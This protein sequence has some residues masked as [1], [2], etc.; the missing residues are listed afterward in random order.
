HWS[1]ASGTVSLSS[2][3]SHASPWAS[4]S[5][6][7]WL[8]F[9]VC[10]QL[11]IADQTTSL[12]GSVQVSSFTRTPQRLSVPVPA[13]AVSDILNDQLPDSDW[14][15]KALSSELAGENTPRYGAAPTMIDDGE[16]SSKT[17]PSKFAPSAAPA[18]S[19]TTVVDRCWIENDTCES[20]GW[21]TKTRTST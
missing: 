18:L 13:A 17:V 9:G 8:T 16:L 1:V 21:V 14:F 10:G 20:S 7:A 11:S 4:K 3:A 5:W 6:S 2:S 19:T 12:S 15:W